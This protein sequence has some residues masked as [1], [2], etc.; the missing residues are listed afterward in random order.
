LR[1]ILEHPW[2]TSLPVATLGLVLLWV[3]LRENL[4][5]RVRAGIASLLLASV[6]FLVGTYVVTPTEHARGIVF[7]FVDAVMDENINEALALL[8]KEVLLV[9]DWKGAQGTGRIGVRESLEEL[10]QRHTLQF[11]TVLKTEIFEGEDDVLV[12]LFLFTRISGIGSVPSTWK[13]HVH[14]REDGVWEL[15]SIDA[16]E[17]GSRSFR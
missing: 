17:I 12:Q 6:L 1:L 16:V 10:F 11:N 2:V 9:D 15:Y 13:I 8:H 14:E 3:G 5:T 4:V 7:A